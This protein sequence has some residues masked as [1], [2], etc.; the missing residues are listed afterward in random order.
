MHCFAIMS[1]LCSSPVLQNCQGRRLGAEK[2]RKDLFSPLRA[3]QPD[4]GARCLRALTTQ[5]LKLCGCWAHWLRGQNG[6]N[7]PSP[8]RE[9]VSL[10]LHP[11]QWRRS[12]LPPEAV[13][14]VG[15]G[16][17]CPS[18]H[19]WSRSGF[20]SIESAFEPVGC[21]GYILSLWG[22]AVWLRRGEAS[23][24]I[25]CSVLRYLGII[26]FNLPQWAGEEP[27]DYAQKGP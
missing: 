11:I 5:L 10:G 16:H 1:M 22:L 27:R 4:S 13:C 2:R 6:V 17:P 25:C 19:N 20:E 26:P 3:A 12:T 7:G 8:L 14:V 24:Q 15:R 23:L 18:W 9:G 21:L